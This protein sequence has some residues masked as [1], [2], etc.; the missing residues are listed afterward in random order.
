MKHSRY[1]PILGGWRQN[2]TMKTE[3]S[4]WAM[5]SPKMFGFAKFLKH[6][7]RCVFCKKLQS[8]GSYSQTLL[9]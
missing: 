5:S 2:G 7:M 3:D 6:G 1:Y 8:A 4:Q 9:F